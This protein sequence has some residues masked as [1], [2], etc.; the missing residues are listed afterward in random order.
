[1]KAIALRRSP[2]DPVAPDTRMQLIAD[3]A[4]V[5]A[6]RPLFLPDFAPSWSGRIGVSCRISRLGKDIAPRFA[7][8]YADAYCLCLHLIPKGIDVTDARGGLFDNCL[9][10]GP[11]RQLPDGGTIEV[12]GVDFLQALDLGDVDFRGAIAAVSRYATLKTGDIIVAAFIHDVA[13]V[14]AGD[15]ICVRV[16]GEEALATRV[17]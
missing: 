1:M 17:R 9:A 8:R 5:G 16:D 15:D 4:I 14:N 2:V 11:W 3:S 12:A 6:G 10:L 13:D 7:D